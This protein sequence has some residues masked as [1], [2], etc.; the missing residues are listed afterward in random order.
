MLGKGAVNQQRCGSDQGDITSALSFSNQGKSIWD[1]RAGLEKAFAQGAYS[2]GLL[3]A[4]PTKG[5]RKAKGTRS[6]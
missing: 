2:V 4:L 5:T 1:R 3:N 6:T